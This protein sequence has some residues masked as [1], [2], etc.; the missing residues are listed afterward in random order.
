[1]SIDIQA[2]KLRSRNCLLCGASASESSIEKGVIYAIQIN[3]S[4]LDPLLFF[5]CDYCH[6]RFDPISRE[7]DRIAF[8]P[9]VNARCHRYAR[10]I[11]LT[12]GQW[13]VEVSQIK[14]RRSKMTTSTK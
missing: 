2:K 3:N 10:Q 12:S 1:M 9:I 8:D 14:V 4:S 7:V 11:G 5:M 6:Q 13:K